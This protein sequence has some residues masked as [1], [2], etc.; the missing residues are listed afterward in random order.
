MSDRKEGQVV[1]VAFPHADYS[2]SK[3]RPALLIKKL[4]GIHGDWLLCA[5]S[6]QL[7]HEIKEFDEVIGKSDQDFKSS[8]LK[9]KSLIRISRLA[10]VNG[11]L[12]PGAIGEI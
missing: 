12:L 3:L 11:N 4:P 6:T 2:K 1:L 5:I 7:H 9:D 10:V 8:G